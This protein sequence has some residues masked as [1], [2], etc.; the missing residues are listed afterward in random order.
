MDF[1]LKN[2]CDTIILGCTHF[3]HIADAVRD[4]AGSGVRVIDSRNGVSRRALDVAGEKM[5]GEKFRGKKIEADSAF[6]VTKKPT[7]AE[8][9]EYRALCAHF[10]IPWGGT[11]DF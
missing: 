6:F 11:V 1:F 5:G 3:T 7:A 10:G 2:D 8:E 9:N 4:V